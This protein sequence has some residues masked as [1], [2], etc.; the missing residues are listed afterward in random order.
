MELQP[1]IEV[2]TTIKG[3]VTLQYDGNPEV[4]AKRRWRAE[5]ALCYANGPTADAALKVCWANY[6]R[7]VAE[8]ET[9]SEGE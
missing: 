9:V 5:I 2:G 8:M 6:Q 1:M 3:R 4:P 7:W